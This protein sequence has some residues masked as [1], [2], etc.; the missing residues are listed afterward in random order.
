M[1]YRL[2]LRA[3]PV[4]FLPLAGCKVAGAPSFPIAGAYFPSWMLCG[5][6]GIVVAVGL[7]IL[8]LATD[9]DAVLRL[10]LFTYVSLGTITALLFW[11]LAFGP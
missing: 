5:V 9:L 1:R 7:R 4:V 10:R 2:L 11:L 6:I 8:F 3:I